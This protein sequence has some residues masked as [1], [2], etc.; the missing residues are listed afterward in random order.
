MEFGEASRFIERLLEEWGPAL[1]RQ[2]F[3]M[4]GDAESAD[5]L[6]QEAFMAL[7]QE[8]RSGASVENARAWTLTVVR[9][10]AAKRHRSREVRSECLEPGDVLDQFPASPPDRGSREPDLRDMLGVLSPREQEVMLLRLDCLKYREIAECL[11][12]DNSSV[13]TLL[14]RAIRKLQAEARE[15]AA[16]A[17]YAR[18]AHAQKAL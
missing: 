6:V 16:G 1:A 8:L 4:T 17:P 3:R 15:R 18:S 11:G 12:I 10:L 9:N 5:D 13:A 2:A 7:F 14:A